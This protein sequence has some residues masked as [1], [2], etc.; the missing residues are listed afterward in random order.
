LISLFTLEVDF[1]LFFST[2]LALG[3]L[4]D[5]ASQYRETQERR[6]RRLPGLVAT[7]SVNSDK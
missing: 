7:Y 3:N 4:K 6:V 2:P 5:K 1:P